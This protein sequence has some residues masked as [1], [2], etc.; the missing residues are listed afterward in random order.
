MRKGAI[1]RR[2]EGEWHTVGPGRSRS[3]AVHGRVFLGQ[4]VSQEVHEMSGSGEGSS[5]RVRFTTLV[6]PEDV[7]PHVDDPDWAIVDCRFWL[8]AT[9]RGRVDYVA[10][11][12]PG[13]VYAHL[14]EDLSGPVMPGRTG[15]HPLPATERFA[16]TLSRWGIDASVQVVAYDA[17]GGAI[18]ARLWWMLRWLGHE[19]VALL[20]GGWPRWQREGLPART[21]TESRVG[22]TFSPRPR[23][24]LAVDA[25]AVDARGSERFR[26]E[27]EPI[28]P[29]AGHIPGAVSAPFAGNLR[30]DGSFLSPGAL[31]ARYDALLSGVPAERVAVY[32][33]SGVTAAHAVL[34][35]AHAG[36]G[37]A[38]LYPGSWSEWITD[39]T[40][41][42]ARE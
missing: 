14:D 20:D 16:A 2:A 34:A 22:R 33:G 5:A 39:P 32:C 10:G 3:R 6:A 37:A 31:R 18:A 7:A 38:R 21:G 24:A 15:R 8:D 12:V 17:A 41:P 26:G 36:L 23:P 4:W 13:A 42:V 30:D 9:Q 27:R 40:R 28:D 25:A 29:V 11:H 19:R 35:L 1:Q